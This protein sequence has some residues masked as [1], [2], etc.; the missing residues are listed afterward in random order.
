M[1]AVFAM[2]AGAQFASAVA[3]VDFESASGYALVGD[4]AGTI[5]R[6][7]DQAHGGAY[8]ARIELPN[9]Q[10]DFAK[11]V[12]DTA[13]GALQLG[14]ASGSF[15]KYVP[16]SSPNYSPYMYFGVD[17]D[18][19]GIF[20]FAGGSDKDSLVI[21]FKPSETVATNQWILDGIDGS[22]PVHVVGNRTGLL[23][24]TYSSSGTQDTLANLSALTL[25]TGTWG[26]LD[27]LQVRVG[28]GETGGVLT[29]YVAY[30]DDVNAV[31][32]PGALS[33]LGIGA[34]AMLRRRRA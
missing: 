7:T 29:D 9:T 8:S 22:T 6:S 2:A 34:A 28:A 31:P 23:G 30:V 21:A 15:W 11:V 16:D 17:T 24:G 18:K 5:L 13:S 19:N 27:I 20:E 4:A 3:S 12:I 33:L 14:G 25:G 1:C 32:E 10:A 26:D